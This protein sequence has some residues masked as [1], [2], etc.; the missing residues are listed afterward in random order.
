MAKG[1]RRWAALAAGV[2]LVGGAHWVSKLAPDAGDASSS[3]PVS[4]EVGEYSRAGNLVLRIDE[5][6]LPSQIASVP[7]RGAE[8]A[9]INPTTG[10]W[11]IVR[12]TAQGHT[13]AGSLSYAEILVETDGEEWHYRAQDRVG[14]T[15]LTD[16]LVNPDVPQ[17]GYLAFEVPAA[18]VEDGMVVTLHARGPT[19]GQ[20]ARTIAVDLDLASARETGE[21]WL[22]PSALEGSDQRIIEEVRDD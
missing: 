12:A 18:V 22:Y 11:I 15:S 1:W 20:Y 8:S 21:V 14:M 4:A 16:T 17:T 7:V 13:D 2:A 19:D 10:R 9:H 6:I 5:V 3:L